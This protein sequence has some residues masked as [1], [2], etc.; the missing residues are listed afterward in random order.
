MGELRGDVV[1]VGFVLLLFAFLLVFATTVSVNLQPDD[2][3]DLLFPVLRL[4]HSAFAAVGFLVALGAYRAGRSGW[5][6]YVGA[7]LV[8]LVQLAVPVLWFARTRK[9]PLAVG[10]FDL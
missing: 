6:L 7:A 10:R 4:G 8:P 2:R 5:W 3:S 9:A 1:V